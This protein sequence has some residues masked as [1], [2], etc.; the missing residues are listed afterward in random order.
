MLALPRS[1]D[2]S[3]RADKPIKPEA[4]TIRLPKTPATPYLKM[5]RP[6]RRRYG[7]AT[8]CRAAAW[9]AQQRVSASERYFESLHPHREHEP[10]GATS[11]GVAVSTGHARSTSE[12]SIAGSRCR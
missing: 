10:A 8:W 11:S 6:R 7:A 2:T 9:H 5:G 3:R 1:R 4:L 12:G